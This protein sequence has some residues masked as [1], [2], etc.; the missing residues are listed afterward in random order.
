MRILICGSNYGASYIRALAASQDRVRLAGILSNGSAR[1]IA[2]AEQAQ[3]PHHTSLDEIADGSIDIACVAVPGAAG[4]QLVLALLAK[5]IHVLCEH[6]VGP[7]Q[8]MQAL[9]AAQGHERVF[10][11]NAHFGD[12]LAPQAFYQGLAVARQ[13]G[14][15]LHYDLALN[16]RTLYSGLDLLGRAIGTLAGIEAVAAFPAGDSPALFA[17]LQLVGPQV[18]V[19]LLC[20]NFASAADDGSA[21]LFNH[22]CS[23]TF[24]H[25]N[26][27]LAESNGPVLWFPTPVSMPAQLW[28]NYLPV[29]MSQFDPGQ[30]QHQRD[31]ANR[32]TINNLIATIEGAATAAQQQPD[33]LLALA[34][35]WQ[36]ILQLLQPGSNEAGQATE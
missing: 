24:A 1:S 22:R 14:P 15:V 26:L 23:A 34:K 29:D 21:T 20:Q 31:Q 28:R 7:E 27:L 32:A 19:S 33:Y 36:Q 8:M 2:Y 35:L 6:P 3:V 30:L 13:M 11:V 16:L 4:H 5:G 25:G 17:N 9:A 10:Q 18:L 12:L